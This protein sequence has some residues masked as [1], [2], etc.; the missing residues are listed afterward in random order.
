MKATKG[1]KY[2]PGNH[3]SKAGKAI[4]SEEYGILGVNEKEEIEASAIISKEQVEELLKK[5]TEIVDNNGDKNFKIPYEIFKQ[6]TER[7]KEL[8][9]E[10]IEKNNIPIIPL[11]GFE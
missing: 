1:L 7:Y 4:M 2:P 11:P 8:K 3:Y 9:E 10:Y 6:M 5:D